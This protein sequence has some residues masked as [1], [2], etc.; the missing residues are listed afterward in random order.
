MKTAY[1]IMSLD[2]RKST[3]HPEI[4]GVDIYSQP[5]GSLGGVRGVV[6]AELLQAEDDSYEKA[7]DRVK[8]LLKDRT[9]MEAWLELEKKLMGSPR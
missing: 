2:F 1:L 9:H 6:Y 3:T 5:A 4:L 7:C 8:A